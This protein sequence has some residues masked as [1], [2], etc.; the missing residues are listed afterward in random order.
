M[1]LGLVFLW[2]CLELPILTAYKG[3][4]CAWFILDLSYFPAFKYNEKEE[5]EGTLRPLHS[6]KEQT[7]F[8]QTENTGAA[9]R[10]TERRRRMW[11]RAKDSGEAVKDCKAGRT[12]ILNGMEHRGLAGWDPGSLEP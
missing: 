10:K 7:L 6:R 12:S 9:V 1:L 3:L 8:S 2:P 4:V 5:K 11:Q